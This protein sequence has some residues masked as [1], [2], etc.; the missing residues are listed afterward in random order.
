[1]SGLCLGLTASDQ[2]KFVDFLGYSTL[3]FFILQGNEMEANM[4][5]NRHVFVGAGA[6]LDSRETY[7]VNFFAQQPLLL[8]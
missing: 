3:G 2:E 7:P 4:I 6:A 1:M 8:D 5:V